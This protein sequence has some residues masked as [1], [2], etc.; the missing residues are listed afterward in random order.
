MCRQGVIHQYQIN[1]PHSEFVGLI[2]PGG[3]ETFFRFIGEPYGGP[4]WPMN[5][6]RKFHEVL[7]PKLKAAS[8]K[9]DMIPCPQQQH[10][11]PQDWTE[12]DSN[13][14]DKG[15]A[16]F[17]KASSGPAYEVGGTVCRPLITTAESDGK[18]SIGSI[19]SS[20]QFQAYGIFANEKRSLRFEDV[21]HAFHVIDGS[22]SFSTNASSPQMLAAGDVLYVPK[23]VSF[24]FR[25]TS[26]F[27]KMYAFA[28]GGGLV[29]LLIELG[30]VHTSSILPERAEE[31]DGGIL[32]SLQTQMGFSTGR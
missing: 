13:L 22:I 27:C 24:R 28:S 29:G 23:G 18:F 4:M 12:D 2:V 6:D 16:Y 8:E 19:E 31:W 15:E 3:W 26:R 32:E 20:S 1:G 5:D 9:F 10:F 30:K 17:L 25:S 14:P 7:L 21:H 11:D